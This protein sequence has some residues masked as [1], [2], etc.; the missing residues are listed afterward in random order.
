M[1]K[2][3]HRTTQTDHAESFDARFSRYR[4]LLLFLA[5]RVLGGPECADEAV[6][7]CWRSASR[8]PPRFNYDGAFCSWLVRILINEAL[9][10]RGHCLGSKQAI[11]S[12]DLEAVS[13][14]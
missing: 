10:I 11:V 8:N 2:K 9:A 13:C 7:N 4:R 5:A 14:T 3:N 6:G 1:P 12:S